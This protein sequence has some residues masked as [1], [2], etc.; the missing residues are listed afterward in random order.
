MEPSYA[1]RRR[2]PWGS[3]VRDFLLAVGL[4]ALVAAVAAGVWEWVWTPP[5]G[6]VVQHHWFAVDSSQ[7]FSATGSYVAVALVA[8]VLT[9]LLVSVLLGGS[10]LVALAGV[11][12]GSVLAAWL[13]ARTGTALGPADPVTLAASA[14]EGAHL[15][16]WLDVRG[17][18]PYVA[19]P[20]GALVGLA[21][22]FVGL[23]R[24]ADRRAA[25]D[26][27]ATRGESGG[28]SGGSAAEPP[29]RQ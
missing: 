29:A 21:A 13:M 12:V 15:P 9:G 2:L 27:D 6:V 22:V 10:E 24:G 8:G 16:G 4:F 20:G 28:E 17:A 18:S 3:L 19:L 11:V 25:R 7:E 14:P 1:E 23:N 26:S 5:D